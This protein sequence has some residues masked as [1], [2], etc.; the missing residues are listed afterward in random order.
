MFELRIGLILACCLDNVLELQPGHL[1]IQLR[2]YDLYKLPCGDVLHDRLKHLL[3][4]LG[5]GVS[6]HRRLVNL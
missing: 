5:R 6:G 3:G 4:L 2:L 1:P